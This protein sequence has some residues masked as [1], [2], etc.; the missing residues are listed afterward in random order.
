MI[1]TYKILVDNNFPKIIRKIIPREI[2]A[3]SY[4]INVDQLLKEKL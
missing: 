4:E 1:E 3:A 2:I